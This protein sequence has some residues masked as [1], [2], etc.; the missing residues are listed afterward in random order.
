[1][2]EVIVRLRSVAF[3]VSTGL[4]LVLILG[5]VVVSAVVSATASDPKVAVVSG[6]TLPADASVDPQDV[7]D[8]DAAEQLLR[9]GE[10]EAAIVPDDGPLGF[11]VLGDDSVPV[12]VVQALSVAPRCSCWTTTARPDSS[13][14]S[15]RSASASCS[16]SRR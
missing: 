3:L 1:M 13:A 5:S 10:V 15:W 9:D 2:R 11:A 16:S 14:T 12:S 7:A 6:V 4:L 8:R